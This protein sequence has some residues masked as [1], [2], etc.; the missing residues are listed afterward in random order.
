[1]SK[2]ETFQCP[3]CGASLDLHHG[4][5]PTTECPYCGTTVIVP[6]ELRETGPRSITLDDLAALGDDE[7]WSAKL[8]QAIRAGRKIEAIKLYRTV[9]GVGL[10]E[11]KETVES[12]AAGA[13]V[14]VPPALEEA[15]TG[16]RLEPLDMLSSMDDTAANVGKTVRSVATTISFTI[17]GV[18]LLILGVVLWTM[19]KAAPTK[20]DIEALKT[21]VAGD[22]PTSAF[23]QVVST[24][25]SEGSGP[26]RFTDA[27][28]VAVDGAGN[29]YVAE[30][31]TGQVHRFDAEGNYAATWTVGSDDAVTGLAADGQGTVY[32][33]QVGDIF[34]YEGVSG[35]LLGQ[36]QYAEGRGFEEV[37]VTR[38]GELVASWQKNRDDIVRFDAEGH[39]AQAIQAAISGQTGDAELHTSVD[40][41]RSGNIYALGRFNSAVFKFAP[42]GKFITRFGSRGDEQGQFRAPQDIAVDW[43]GRVF[44]SDF[45]GVQVFSGDG[46]YLALIDV[47]DPAFGLAFDS[48]NEL[49]VASR[50]RVVKLRLQDER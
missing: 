27:R 25:G 36:V 19:Q 35:K 49:I 21:S 16:H 38:Q 12:L 4:D 20:Q 14:T 31:R 29:L 11:A 34:R 8:V 1:M 23:A 9:A 42:D 2:A 22:M 45:R 46:R 47:A 13:A 37:A 40:V 28:H 3:N 50:D 17:M 32:V 6:H 30:Y 24:V 41:D 43:E 7:V 5:D 39:V 48:S 10:K 15:L 26:G 33:V 18:T 44:V